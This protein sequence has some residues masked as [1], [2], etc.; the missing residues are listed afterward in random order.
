MRNTTSPPLPIKAMIF[1]LDGTLVDTLPV[2]F[3]A[4]RETFLRFSGRLYSDEEI[5]AMF[6][7][8]EE[9]MIAPRVNPSVYHQAYDFLIHRYT[10]LHRSLSEPFPGVMKLLKRL[11]SLGIRRGIVTGKGIGT[12]QVTIEM[13]GLDIY[14][15][16]LAIGSHSGPD[17]PRALRQMLAKWGLNAEEAAYVGDVPSDVDAAREVGMIPFGAAWASSSKIQADTPA[18]EIF[19]TVEDLLAWVEKNCA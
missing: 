11:R 10:E 9:G 1:D 6:G 13:L 2:I 15:E 8:T 7:P 5:T 18:E 4:F 17:K 14:I 12:A 19:Y 3:P 16:E